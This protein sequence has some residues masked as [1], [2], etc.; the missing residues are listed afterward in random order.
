MTCTFFGHK[1]CFEGIKPK[2]KEVIMN[3]ID[4]FGVDL[5]LVGDKGNFDRIVKSALKEIAKEKPQIKYYV[6][7]PYLPGKPTF[8]DMNKT[9]LPEGVENVP[10]KFAISYVNKWMIE[11]SECSIVYVKRNFGGAYKFSKMA[12]RKHKIYINLSEK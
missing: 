10:R 1:D 6:V 7:T 2:L 11:N 4:N 8:Y 3:L 12:K 9:V 5:F